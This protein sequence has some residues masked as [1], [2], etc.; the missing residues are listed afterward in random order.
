MA[1]DPRTTEAL[2]GTA[3]LQASV[4]EFTLTVLDGDLPGAVHVFAAERVVVGADA[5]AALTI[6]D[7]AMS[8]F[9]C[10]LRITDGAAV[11]RDLGSRNG[12]LVD[13]VPVIEAPLRP[14]AVLGLGRTQLRFDLGTRHHQLALSPHDR[15]GRLRGASVRMR[16]VF[17]LLES[18]AAASATVLVQGESGT[19]KELVAE[20]LH[21][22]GP[23]RDGPLVVVDCGAIPPTLLETELFGHEAGAFTGAT[24]RRVGAFE[25]AAGG[26]L[27]L[28][29]IGELALDLQ[30]KLLRAI[31]QRAIQRV[32]ASDRIPVDV[33][34]VAATNRDLKAEVNARRFRSDLYYRLAVVVVTM[35]PLRERTTDIPLL[36]DALLDELAAPDD[37]M[38][39]ELRSGALWPELLRHGWPGNVRELRNYVEAC[40]VRQAHALTDPGDAPTIDVRQPLRVVREQWTRHVE[41]RYLEELLRVHHGNVS[42]AARAAG[43]DRVHL[44]RLLARV[45]LR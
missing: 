10:E 43:V 36:V 28:D 13:R 11:V 8:K 6:A 45:G 9:H 32:G 41:R 39:R 26:T 7:P 34:V 2:T 37:P 24:T 14:G 20:A 29:E 35:P 17:A 40:L 21:S 1:I 27:V 22:E 3:P 23:R 25:A 30:P 12:T 44:H 15:F 16:S 42:A 4:R 33:R 19:G 31:E 18:A 5:A 38:A